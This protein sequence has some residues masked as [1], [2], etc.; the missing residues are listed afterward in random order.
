VSCIPGRRDHNWL[1]IPRAAAQPAESIPA[2]VRSLPK[3]GEIGRVCSM[4]GENRNAY[5]IMVGKP[6]VKRC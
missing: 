2:V 3:E 1:H 4:N 5:R 6:E